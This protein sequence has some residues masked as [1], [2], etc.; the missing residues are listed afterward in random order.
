MNISTFRS[1]AAALLILPILTVFSTAQTLKSI[2]IKN[3]PH[4]TQLPDFCG[5][6]CAE[7]YLK[8]LKSS[9]TQN[10]IF[11]LAGCDPTLGRG[12]RA[13]ELDS[14]LRAIGFKPGS[15]WFYIPAN[16]KPDLHKLFAGLHADLARGVPSIVCMRTSA[17][18][19][20]TEHFR[21][22][23]GFDSASRSIIYHEP[24]AKT[25]AY[26]TMK[27]N[28]FLQLWPLK[29]A[30]DQWTVIRFALDTA[31]PLA[32]APEYPSFSPAQY[33]QHI[34]ALKARVPDTFTILIEPPFV[35]LGNDDSANVSYFAQRTVRWAVSRLKKLYFDKDPSRIIDI[36]LFKDEPTYMAGSKSLLGCEPSTPFGFYLAGDDALVMNI[37]TGGGTLV[38]EIVHPFM[39]SNF[40]GC[41]AWLNEGMGSLYEQSGSRRDTIIGL[42]N[43]RLAGLQNAI[44]AAKVPPFK[45]L[46]S[47][48]DNEFYIEDKGTNYAQARYLCY[49]LQE[50]G[51]LAAFYRAFR[52][53][54][55]ADP[56]GYKTLEKF[57]GKPGMDV[58]QK[59]WEQYVLKLVF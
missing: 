16:S 25:G 21:L 3:I 17:L 51:L 44:R 26:Q 34:M 45:T 28:T 47:T 22:I 42:T 32:Q 38:H 56:T 6:A 9:L 19:S 2:T 41:P 55:R 20:A 35:V 31:G 13:P 33:C 14:A 53:N 57:V 29:Y 23:T 5:E 48:T 8:K 59:Q 43:W 18:P 52:D 15:G 11:N 58:F 12:C 1:L 40:P 49:W 30:K 36:W 50:H 27:L 46:L 4:I 37:A 7:M 10:D 24:A 39:E 54:R